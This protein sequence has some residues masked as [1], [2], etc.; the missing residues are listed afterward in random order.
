MPSGLISALEQLP[1]VTVEVCTLKH[2]DIEIQEGVVIERKEA[3]DFINSIID[4]RLFNQR[5]EAKA[6][7]IRVIYLVIGDPYRT[8]RNISDEAVTGALSWLA[9]IEDAPVVTIPRTVQTADA[10]KRIAMHVIDGLGYEIN[11][12]AATPKSLPDQQRYILVGL[13]G[14]GLSKADALLEHFGSPG[15]VLSASEAALCEV[16]GIGKKLASGI[17]TMLDTPT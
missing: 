11:L 7:G 13:P 6:E 14:V 16:K 3:T 2:G 10:I 9:V 4:R 17:R 15:A 12:R 8:A 5:E 1:E